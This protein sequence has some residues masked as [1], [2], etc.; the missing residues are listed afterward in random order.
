MKLTFVYKGSAS[1]GFH[2]HAGRPGEVGGSTSESTDVTETQDY[3]LFN[4]YAQR[5]LGGSNYDA[6]AVAYDLA[7]RNATLHS[8]LLHQQFGDTIPKMTPLYRIGGMEEG[9]QS[10]FT[11]MNSAM[12]YQRRMGVDTINEYSAS[13]KY[14]VP[15]GAGSGEV[16]VDIENVY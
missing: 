12:S 16:W 8:Y 2:G 15:T 9:I 14:V 1:S 11:D 13:T 6:K 10:F 5:W 4:T 3:E 7:L